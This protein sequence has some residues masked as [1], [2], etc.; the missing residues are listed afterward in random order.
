V[1]EPV[2]GSGDYRI[3]PGQCQLVASYV[4]AEDQRILECQGFG[5]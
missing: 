5:G 4:A 2:Q 3:C 1:Y